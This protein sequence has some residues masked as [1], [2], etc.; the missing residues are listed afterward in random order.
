MHPLRMG[1][2]LRLYTL[3]AIAAVAAVLPFARVLGDLYNIWNLK[4]EYSHGVIIP[5]ISAFLIWRQRDELRHLPFT[6]SWTGVVLIVIGLVMRFI[7]ASTTMHTL[8]H[9]AFLFV[10]YGVVLALTGPV[11]FRR[12]WVPLAM[13]IFAVPLP[14]FFNSSLCLGHS[15][16]RHRRTVG[17]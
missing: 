2:P 17:R 6:G 13:L 7:G 12:L 11:I 14:S 9:Y 16:R 1:Q 8:E 15:C 3:F 4:P 10:L 5:L